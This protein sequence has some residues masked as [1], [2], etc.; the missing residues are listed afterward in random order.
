MNTRPIAIDVDFNCSDFSLLVDASVQHD[1]GTTLFMST[2]L[3]D[4]HSTSDSEF[5]VDHH[6]TGKSS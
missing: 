3:G 5:S 1:M 2:P 4:Y 6:E